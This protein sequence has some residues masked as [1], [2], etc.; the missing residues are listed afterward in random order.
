MKNGHARSFEL[1][2]LKTRAKLSNNFVCKQAMK[3]TTKAAV[4]SFHHKLRQQLLQLK[5]G[6]HK[7]I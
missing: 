7:G 4:I 3:M 2:N 6:K 5:R 1:K